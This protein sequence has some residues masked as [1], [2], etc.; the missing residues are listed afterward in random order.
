M[1][2]AQSPRRQV[3]LQQAG[4]VHLCVSCSHETLID[5]R[6]C[7]NSHIRQ[8]RAAKHSLPHPPSG[9]IPEEDGE[10]DAYTLGRATPPSGSNQAAKRS[11]TP[12]LSF[13]HSHSS[14]YL[15]QR[16]SSGT[17]CDKTGRPR[18]TEIQFHCSMTHSDSIY[19]VK[20]LATCSYVLVIH[21]PHLCELPG[22]KPETAVGQVES[23][24]CRPVVGDDEAVPVMES[25]KA[26]RYPLGMKVQ[27]PSLPAPP[28][29]PIR[30]VTRKPSRDQK[31]AQPAPVK[32]PENEKL[33]ALEDK[34]IR[35][36]AALERLIELLH[37]GPGAAGEVELTSLLEDT[38]GGELVSD[39]ERD[40][41]AEGSKLEL[42]R[43][44]LASI[45]ANIEIRIEDEEEMDAED[46]ARV[47]D[48]L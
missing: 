46:E 19:L 45:D 2:S 15:L 8:F 17:M 31:Q 6:Y 32:I 38:V 43:S 37:L 3:H 14:R 7:H 16:M 35:S 22:F 30:K 21:S 25:S 39:E 29:P 27:R 18:E 26:S 9:Y 42:L 12:A 10:F 40:E 20:E 4:L 13:G 33:E 28:S 44:L 34:L 11:E 23:V 5:A 47:R 24:K 41:V 1:A 36:E 48:E